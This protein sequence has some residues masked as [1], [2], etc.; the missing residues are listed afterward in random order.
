MNNRNRRM[1]EALDTLDEVA[2]VVTSIGIAVSARPL[3]EYES[4]GVNA[5]LDWST[6]R[7]RDSL[8]ILGDAV[9]QDSPP[10]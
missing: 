1:I 8:Q 6:Q 7:L 3:D 9:D 10:N 2:R 5:V 4:S